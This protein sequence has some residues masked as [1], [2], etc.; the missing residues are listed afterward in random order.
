MHEREEIK[1]YKVLIIDDDQDICEI[2]K[3]NI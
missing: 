2:V 3:T 1:M